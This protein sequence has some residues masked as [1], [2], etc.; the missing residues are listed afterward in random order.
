MRGLKRLAEVLSTVAAH[1]GTNSTIIKG[2]FINR[3]STTD[4]P[5]Q[6]N[7]QPFFCVVAQ[8]G[9]DVLVN[10]RPYH[11]FPGKYLLCTLGVPMSG[12]VTQASS[13]RPYL[14]LSLI[15]D[16]SE[17]ASIIRDADLRKPVRQITPPAI[18]AHTIDENLLDA[19][20][21]L[22]ELLL[23]PE[24]A[25]FFA[26]LIRREIYYKLLVNGNHALIQRMTDQNSK[27]QRVLSGLAWLKQNA[28]RDVRMTELARQLNMSTSSMNAW[29]RSVTAM[30]PLQFQKQL[31]LQEA[32][33]MMTSQ[34]V[35]ATT[36]SLRVGYE[37]VSQFNREYK[38]LFG[39]PPA[40]DLQKLRGC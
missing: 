23:I 15:L 38:R 3:S 17:I 18:S 5:R 21:R 39:A 29:F 24:Q 9:K 27:A 31:R 11:C 13:K 10:S 30:S 33:L 37:S 26:P 14:G 8:G 35:D 16:F 1:D 34:N 4:V 40:L 28:T 2:V 12:Q 25:P 6:A 7:D 22:A 20:V 19:V 36:A 32:R